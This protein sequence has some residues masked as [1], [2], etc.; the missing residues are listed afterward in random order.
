MLKPV[1]PGQIVC[2]KPGHV[3]AYLMSPTLDGHHHGHH[4]L[5]KVIR[6]VTFTGALEVISRDA[7]AAAA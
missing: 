2:Y 7:Q 3:W 1:K 6:G 5:P 4:H